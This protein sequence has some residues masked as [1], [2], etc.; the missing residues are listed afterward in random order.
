MSTR[1]RTSLFIAVISTLLVAFFAFGC[2]DDEEDDNGNGNGP[3]NGS[4]NGDGGYSSML[5]EGDVEGEFEG[6]AT[7]PEVLLDDGTFGIDLTDNSEFS[8]NLRIEVAD[9]TVPEPGT[10]DI[11]TG[12]GFSDEAFTAIYADLREGMM[13][14][15]EYTALQE[16]SGQVEIT[17]SGEDFADG[18]F[19]FEAEENPFDEAEDGQIQVEG[20]FEAV[21]GAGGD[22]L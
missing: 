8:L 12:G 4:G 7:F 10:Y 22:R 11:G 2:G 20:Q 21:K 5:V 1:S 14:A 3:G 16:G 17:D 6:F 18:T 9:G 15:T 13:E 19:E